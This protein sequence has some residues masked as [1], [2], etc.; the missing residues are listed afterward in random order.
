MAATPRTFY[1]IDE[2]KLAGMARPSGSAD[3]EFLKDQ[4]IKL[5][6]TLTE[7]SLTP[8]VVSEYGFTALHLPMVDFQPPAPSQI[9]AFVDAVGEVIAQDRAAVVH[10]LAGRG[11]T[12]TLAACYLVSQG[13]DAQAA[14][15][16]VRRLSPGS[17]ET[18]EQEDAVR[19]YA[20]RRSERNRG[21]GTG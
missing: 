5:I 12:G 18:R 11:R 21:G 17:I 15:R 16:E 9:D 8:S 3:F 6:V 10:C 13:R 19:A 20:L 7:Y 4:G 14:I 1:W 2:G